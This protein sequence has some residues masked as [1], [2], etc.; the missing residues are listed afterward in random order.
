MKSHS[1]F[2]LGLVCLL[3]FAAPTTAQPA[4]P[5]PTSIV[6]TIAIWP[7]TAPDMQNPPAGET[8]IGSEG[9]RSYSAISRPTLTAFYSSNPNG[10]AVLVL[11]GGGYNKVVFDK[12]GAEIARWLNALGIDAFVLKYRLLAETHN[13]NP[14]V[15]LED[16]QRA[17]RMIRSGRLSASYGHPLDP[18]K[19]GVIG[20]SAGGNLAAIVSNYHASKTYEPVDEYDALSARPDF[21]IL[22]Y[23]WVPLKDELRES[24][25]FPRSYVFAEKVSAETPPMFVFTG[26]A[27][28]SVPSIHSV[29][30]AEALKGAGVPVELRIYSGAPHGFAL[31]GTGEE[32]AWPEHCAA[33]L[34]ARH[35][36]P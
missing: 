30:V 8:V 15:G 26:D 23:A 24:M 32:K 2:C 16:V 5:P 14:A 10:A 35:I 27:D 6:D 28:K 22:G 4:T 36:I 12:E 25:V 18:K 17:M 1:S 34:R 11:P 19:I 29:R 13:S 31:R 20:F 7:G 33:W 9:D 3:T 21:A